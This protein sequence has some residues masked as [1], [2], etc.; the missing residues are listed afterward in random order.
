VSLFNNTTGANNTAVGNI[1]G[2]SLTTGSN[3]IDIGYNVTGVA[4]ESNTIRIGNSDI[5]NTF[6][7]GI[8]GTN[9]PGGLAVFCNSDGKLG[10]ISSSARFKQNIEPMG[11]ASEAILALRPVS[12]QYKTEFDPTGI[13]QFGLVAEDVAKVEP[14]LVVRDKEGKPYSVRYE[15]VNAMLLNEFLKEHLK[16]EEQQKELELLKAELNEQRDLIQKVSDKLQMRESA[17]LVTEN[18]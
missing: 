10:V 7:S 1:A 13:T 8:S 5:T 6:I 11:I 12:F 2:S 9:S 4:G 14:D 16:V 15:Q 17:Q 18:P 3:N